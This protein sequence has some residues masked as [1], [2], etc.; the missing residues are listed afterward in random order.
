MNKGEP[1]TVKERIASLI[2][3][4]ILCS[5]LVVMVTIIPIRISVSALFIVKHNIIIFTE[6]MPEPQMKHWSFLKFRNERK[7][8]FPTQD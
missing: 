6:I 4:P 2:W 7:G 5:S 1:A 8:H 3:H